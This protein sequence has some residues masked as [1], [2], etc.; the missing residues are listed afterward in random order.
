[1]ICDLTGHAHRQRQPARRGTAAAEALHHAVPTRNQEEVRCHQSPSP[2]TA[3]ADPIAVLATRATTAGLTLVDVA[4]GDTVP[5]DRCR[6]WALRRRA[7]CNIRHHRCGSATLHAE[8]AAA[9]TSAQL[10]I[11]MRRPA[12][13]RAA[14]K[15]PGEMG[16]DV[17]RRLRRSASACPWASAARMP[18]FFATRDAFR[19][20][21]PGRLVGVRVKDA[22]GQP[23]LRLACRPA[24]STSAARRPPATS[25]PPRCCWRHRRDVCRV[26]HG[27][28]GLRRIARRVNLQARSLLADAASPPA[29]RCATTPSSIH[30]MASMRPAAPAAAA[31]PQAAEAGADFNF[32]RLSENRASPSPSTRPSRRRPTRSAGRPAGQLAELHR[33]PAPPSHPR[34]P[35]AS[36]ARPYPHAARVFNAYHA[37]HE[38]LRY[39]KRPRIDKDVALNRSMIPLG[40]CT[41]KLNATA[42]MIPITWPRFRRHPPLRASRPA[43]TAATD[44]LIGACRPGCRHHRLRRR[45]ACNPTPAARA[46]TPACWPSAATTARRRPRTATSASSPAAPTAPTPPAP[47]WPADRVV[48]TGA[49]TATATSTS[50][51]CKP[52]PRSTPP[53]LAA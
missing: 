28:A 47:S 15:P 17:V 23:A 29:S 43:H 25:A 4:P 40:S 32:R 16:A 38:M 11:V 30:A 22:A 50:P 44:I 33:P 7:R 46:S 34:R 5:S 2:P 3:S 27:P 19:R 6:L 9:T 20:L 49:A 39:L 8:I 10:A 53:N 42:E 48:V 41:M 13:P 26:W 14:D 21:M 12:G 35:R 37:E 1:M 45:L 18:G 52:K 24:S 31:G 36:A 51:T